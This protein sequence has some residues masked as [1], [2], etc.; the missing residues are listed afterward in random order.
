MHGAGEVTV[1]QIGGDL[2]YRMRSGLWGA[3]WSPRRQ[4]LRLAK[5]R[6]ISPLVMAALLAETVPPDRRAR[7]RRSPRGRQN[8]TSSRVGIPLRPSSEVPTA[9]PDAVISESATLP[10]T[11][12]IRV[13][14]SPKISLRVV[15]LRGIAVDI[16]D[17]PSGPQIVA[18]RTAC[19][20]ARRDDH[21]APGGYLPDHELHSP[22][23]REAYQLPSAKIDVGRRLSSLPLPCAPKMSRGIPSPHNRVSVCPT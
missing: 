9:S 8:L 7:Q 18:R 2:A 1:E 21:A 6:L 22:V 10:P 5:S 4:M 19:S 17:R 16:P 23:A 15:Q 11:T 13:S 14:P 3:R 12:P 20:G